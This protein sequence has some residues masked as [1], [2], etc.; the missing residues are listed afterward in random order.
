MYIKG[1]CNTAHVMNP[2]WCFQTDD[3]IVLLQSCWAEL[4]CLSVCWH[5]VRSQN[6][7][8]LLSHG[9]QLD[10]EM[11][12]AMGLAEV[13]QRLLDFTEHLR[14]LDLDLHE[15]ISLKVLMLMTPG[16]GHFINK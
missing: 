15:Y 13:I 12:K 8:L 3:Q 5:S 16:K 10:L 9:R 2:L 4:L 14:R 6:N 11:A 7:T 1:F